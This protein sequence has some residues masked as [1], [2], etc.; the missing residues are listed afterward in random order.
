MI[1]WLGI[2]VLIV[3]ASVIEFGF[4]HALPLPFSTLP[5]VA[6]IG[7]Y[8]LFTLRPATGLAW[9][10]AAGLISDMHAHVPAGE[11]L[12][13]VVIG[14]GMVYTVQQQLSHS[15][16]YAMMSLSAMGF[17]LW[18]LSAGLV[19]AIAFQGRLDV[20]VILWTTV[21]GALTSTLLLLVLPWIRTRV[22]AY[23]RFSV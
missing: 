18:S 13:A 9:I 5:L 16:L 10:G 4:L 6:S 11:I 14:M 20:G 17:F 22:S 3:M 23:I 8:C 1:R 7:V 2:G 19:R 21:M 15:S 12:I